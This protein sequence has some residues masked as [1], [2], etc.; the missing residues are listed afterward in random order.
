LIALSATALQAQTFGPANSQFFFKDSS[1][2]PASAAILRHYRRVPIV[3]PLANVDPRL[4]P[5]LRRAAT[6]AE[7]RANAYSKALCWR[8]VKGALLASGAVN[9]YPKSFYA[10]QAGAEL[11]RY[12]G[13]TKLPVRDP[14]AAPLGSVL[15]YGQGIDGAGHVEIRTRNGFVSDYRTKSRCRYPLLAVYAKF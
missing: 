9:F 8:Y 14:Y 4:D 15:V 6:I 11:V 10:S 12:H 1:G 2:K 7:E 5:T 13:F 3:H